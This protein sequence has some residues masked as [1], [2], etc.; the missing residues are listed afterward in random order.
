MSDVKRHFFLSVC[1]VP[2]TS[3][4]AF[5]VPSRFCSVLLPLYSSVFVVSFFPPSLHVP[6][7]SRCP[8]R[9]QQRDYDPVLIVGTWQKGNI[10]TYVHRARKILLS[11]TGDVGQGQLTRTAMRP[12]HF[13]NGFALEVLLVYWWRLPKWSSWLTGPCSKGVVWHWLRHRNWWHWFIM[14]MKDKQVLQHFL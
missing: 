13:N 10:V 6:F 14:Y 12:E 9:E 5:E 1:F 8:V 3:F 4:L 7:V 2:I 11:L